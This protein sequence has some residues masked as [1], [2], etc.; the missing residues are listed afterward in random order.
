MAAARATGPRLPVP[1]LGDIQAAATG[2]HDALPVEVAEYGDASI[3]T[4]S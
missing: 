2:L 4:I 1:F 3:L